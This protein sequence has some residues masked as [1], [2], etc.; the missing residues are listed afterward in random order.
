MTE[1]T[2]CSRPTIGKRS[3]RGNRGSDTCPHL[4]MS[5][6]HVQHTGGVPYTK[7]TV[8]LFRG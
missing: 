5:V 7:R 2:V 4:S 6:E 8:F 3:C 1:G